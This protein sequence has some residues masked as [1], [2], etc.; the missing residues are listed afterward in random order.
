MLMNATLPDGPASEPGARPTAPVP[1]GPP[2]WLERAFADHHQDVYRAAH[3]VTGSATD[4]EDVLQT[5]FTRLLH[6]AKAHDRPE[7]PVGTADLGRYLHRA[8]VNAALDVVR[9]RQRS[10]WAPLEDVDLQRST[11]TPGHLPGT[12]PSD[13]E[14]DAALRRLRRG[15]RL[16]LCRL[17]PRAAEAFALRYFE[18]LGNEQIAQVLETSSGAVAVLLHRTRARLQKELVA[19]QGA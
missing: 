17:S 2:A 5:V 13:P 12:P 7:A 6:R 11:A 14:R 18:G 8:A 19:L 9:S 4:A 3:R 1:A 16:A 15:L 10:G